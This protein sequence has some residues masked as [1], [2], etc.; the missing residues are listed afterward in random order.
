MWFGV[1]WC[2]SGVYG[3]VVLMGG[4]AH[5]EKYDA[6]QYKWLPYTYNL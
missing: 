6:L 2:G 5:D 4:G 3:V 1:V